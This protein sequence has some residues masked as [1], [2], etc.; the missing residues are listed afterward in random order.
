MCDEAAPC[1]PLLMDRVHKETQ[2]VGALPASQCNHLC[3]LA[4]QQPGCA[5]LSCHSNTEMSLVGK[6]HLRTTAHPA[7]YFPSLLFEQNP[8]V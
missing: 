7:N 1:P 2:E 4:G 6:D 3:F 8:V 5:S